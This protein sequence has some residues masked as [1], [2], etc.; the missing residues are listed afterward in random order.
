ML[1]KKLSD[2]LKI[3]ETLLFKRGKKCYFLKP[4]S[5]TAIPTLKPVSHCHLHIMHALCMCV[6]G[7]LKALT[8]TSRAQDFTDSPA[9]CKQ[10]TRGYQSSLIMFPSRWC[11]IQLN[12]P[13]GTGEI[14]TSPAFSCF[15]GKPKTR[16]SKHSSGRNPL[17]FI[18]F[19]FCGQ[20]E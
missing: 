19:Y 10:A 14:D 15:P 20:P 8:I 17:F 4:I 1:S 3:K 5:L 16:L 7:A 13:D 18:F 11:I 2:I 9:K 6:P 12:T